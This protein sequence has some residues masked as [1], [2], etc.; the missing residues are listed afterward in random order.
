MKKQITIFIAIIFL[1]SCYTLKHQRPFSVSTKDAIEI[2]NTHPVAMNNIST[3]IIHM[4][5][6]AKVTNMR[7]E[8]D[9]FW[10]NNFYYDF[11]SSKNY[12]E[13]MLQLNNFNIYRENFTAFKNPKPSMA[14][15]QIYP[16]VKDL[17]LYQVSDLISTSLSGKVTTEWVIYDTFYEKVVYK[18]EFIGSTKFL[19]LPKIKGTQVLGLVAEDAF[20]NGF[21]KFFYDNDMRTILIKE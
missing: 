7:K 13:N 10:G 11:Y 8:Y 1:S 5:H 19:N 4:Q 17:S 2:E 15:F 21:Q 20:N 6:V 16:Y 18:K 14:R 12:C 3:E 9:F